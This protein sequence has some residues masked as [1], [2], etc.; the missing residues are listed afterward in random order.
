MAVPIPDR[1]KDLLQKKAFAQVATVMPDGSPQ[2]TPVWSDYDGTHIRIN[3]AKGRQIPPPSR[4][5]ERKRR[6]TVAA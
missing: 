3:S 6:H 4:L 2:V 5:V 1:F